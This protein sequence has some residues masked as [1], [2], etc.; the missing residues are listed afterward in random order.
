[1]RKIYY[2]LV[3]LYRNIKTAIHFKKRN[4]EADHQSVHSEIVK[5]REAL[6]LLK[7]GFEPI[8]VTCFDGSGHDDLFFFVRTPAFMN[9]LCNYRK[10][11]SKASKDIN[12]NYDF[13]RH[14]LAEGALPGSHISPIDTEALSKIYAPWKC[15]KEAFAYEALPAEVRR[16]YIA[17]VPEIRKQMIDAVYHGGAEDGR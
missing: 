16:E 5:L 13:L 11:I 9:K 3:C 6:Y 1:M 7:C 12:D 17:A 15:M 2:M 10:S 14:R 8:K 4:V